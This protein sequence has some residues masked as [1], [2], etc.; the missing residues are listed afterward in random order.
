[1]E[2]YLKELFSDQKYNDNN[3]FLTA[4]PCVV[5]GE[6]IVMDI[7]KNVATIGGK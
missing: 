3:F 1:M 2:K 4:G 5:E 7:A 6:D